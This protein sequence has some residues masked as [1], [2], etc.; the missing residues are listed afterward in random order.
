[1][2]QYVCIIYIYIYTLYIYIYTHYIFIHTYIYIHYIYAMHL[3][4]CEPYFTQPSCGQA[5][6]WPGDK[7]VPAEVQ[8]GAQ[9]LRHGIAK[10]WC[11]S[12][13]VHRESIGFVQIWWFP[14]FPQFIAI[15]LKNMIW[16]D[17][18]LMINH[19]SRNI[20]MLGHS[21]RQGAQR[22]STP[23]PQACS[24]SPWKGSQVEN[25]P[26]VNIQKAIENGHRNSGFSH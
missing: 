22:R 11:C 6:E 2:Y 7:D 8:Q 21:C 12:Q 16:H 1:M 19:W 5:T 18:I 9:L 10:P 25:Y 20:N 14:W 24:Q 23:T 13:K 3:Y 4:G 17:R 15:L 26:L